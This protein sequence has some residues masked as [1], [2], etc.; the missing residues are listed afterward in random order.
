MNK[1]VFNAPLTFNIS[2]G[3][4]LNRV[5]LFFIKKGDRMAI[6]DNVKRFA[7]YQGMSIRSL[8]IRAGLSNGSISKWNDSRPD[9]FKVRRVAGILDV[10]I[11]DLLS[12][13]QEA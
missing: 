9:V 3:Y 10:T 8:E 6:Y 2:V 13:K 5:N 1:G 7:R 12:S 4:F 11:D